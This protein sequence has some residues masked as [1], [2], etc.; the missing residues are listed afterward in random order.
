[1]HR[2][3]TGAD[4]RNYA[5]LEGLVEILQLEYALE[6]SSNYIAWK[7]RLE[8]VLEDNGLKDFI[9]TDIPKPGSSDAC[10]LYTSPSPR[11]S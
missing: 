9:D 5:I 10:L 4:R 2:C 11:D 7:D 6:G 8:V 1:M 3:G